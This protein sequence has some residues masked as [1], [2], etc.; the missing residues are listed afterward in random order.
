MIWSRPVWSVIHTLSVHAVDDVENIQ[1]VNRLIHFICIKI[2]CKK[3]K[4]HA[5]HYL[6]KF[7]NDNI[8]TFY[9]NFHN[10]VKL[11]KGLR[12]DTNIQNVLEQYISK[13]PEEELIKSLN[14]L[15]VKRKNFYIQLLK[16]IKFNP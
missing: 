5:L 13:K 1:K 6:K 7:N 10:N 9:F 15:R 11:R 12:I 4:I 14:V 8:K 3:C 2:P 16:E